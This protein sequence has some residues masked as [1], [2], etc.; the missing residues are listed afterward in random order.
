MRGPL[1]GRT[2]IVTGAGY[3]IGAA[4]SC[5]LSDAGA[6]VVLAARDGRALRS[7]AADIGSAGGHAV[8][9]PTDITNPV[10]VRR[11]VEQTLGAFGRLDAAFNHAQV[12]G[13]SLAMKYEIP[14]MRRHG[15]G[16]V[17]NLARAAGTRAAVTELTRA[18]AL[19]FADSG[20]R[21]NAVA[22]GPHDSAQDVAG[23]VVW[24]CSDGASL[25]TGEILCLRTTDLPHPLRH[26]RDRLSD[27]AWSD[28]RK[29]SFGGPDVKTA[30]R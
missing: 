15:G 8:A 19:D 2:A 29:P 26:N 23:A 28:D 13:V 30:R 4:T 11:L 20:V 5:A 3:A 18:A 25:A 9:V 27:S 22:A 10:S 12:L 17:V 14:A 24:L 1:S 6:S 7:L 16:R 21:V